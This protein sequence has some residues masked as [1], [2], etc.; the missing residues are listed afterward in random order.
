MDYFVGEKKRADDASS[1]ANGL[2][3]PITPVEHLSG[4][5]S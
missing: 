1:A 3:F 2:G 4:K 5:A